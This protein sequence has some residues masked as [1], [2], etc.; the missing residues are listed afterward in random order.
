MAFIKCHKCHYAAA[1]STAF[2]EEPGYTRSLEL[3]FR[4][5]L[6]SDTKSALK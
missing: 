2:L 4:N 1:L 3:R 6:K 5:K